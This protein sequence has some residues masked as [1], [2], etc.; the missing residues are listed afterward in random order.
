MIMKNRYAVL[1]IILLAAGL[2]MAAIGVARGEAQE[3]LEKAI[4]ICMEC[5]G[6]G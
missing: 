4:I 1:Q 6:I 5:I 3:I 2:V